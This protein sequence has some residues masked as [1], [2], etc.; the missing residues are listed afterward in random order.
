MSIWCSLSHIGTDTTV[1]YEVAEGIY[2]VDLTKDGSG[3]DGRTPVEPVAERGKVLS[4][5]EGFSNHYPDDTGTH[6]TPA[7]I[8]LAYVAPWC[9]PGHDQ[10]GDSFSCTGC[11]RQHEDVADVGDR[12]RL[13]VDAPQALSF[14]REDGEDGPV[15]KPAHVS[16]VL[17][18]E[19]ARQLRDDL[20]AWLK[21]K[22]VRPNG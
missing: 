3:A 12:V 20:D 21:A 13:D 9:V 11:G 2:E 16:V 17:D 14:W 1:M 19:A 5:A 4:Y 18:E 8:N 22:K 15:V 6:E 7:S 10:D